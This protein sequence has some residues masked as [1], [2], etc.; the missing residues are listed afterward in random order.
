MQKKKN[1]NKF[2]RFLRV[3]VVTVKR[4]NRKR[5]KHWFKVN[6]KTH[7]F[8]LGL[9]F[10]VWIDAVVLRRIFAR[11]GIAKALKFHL[12][13]FLAWLGLVI[14]SNLLRDKQKVKWYLKKR[15]IFFMLI[16]LPPLGLILLWSGSQF[17]RITKIIFSIGFGAFFII[18]NLHYNKKYERLLAVPSFDRIVE[19]ITK[20]KKQIF[21]KTA[22]KGILDNLR[23][24]R[25]PKKTAAKLAVSEIA[26]RCSGSIVS[27][28][29][30]DKEGK[31]MGMGSGFIISEDGLIVTNFHV[32]ESAYQIEIKIGEKIFREAS[33]V[34]GISN[35]DIA[36]LK[37]DSK[38]LP[39]LP[40]GDSDSLVD[41][42]FVIVLGNPVGLER[43][44]SNGI[45]SA[46]RSKD[47]I[48]IIQ[49]TAPVSPGSSGG[50]VL[51]E[52]GE[53]VG[54]TTLASFFMAQNLNF[55]IPINYLDKILNEKYSA[56]E[57][58]ADVK[59]K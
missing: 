52:Y 53:V 31:E 17:K 33:L 46:I 2:K 23:L 5:V 50:P 36:L 58:R 15:F 57:K 19:M 42:Q 22:D 45:I 59:Q 38:G 41:G 30:K 35:M 44:V 24:T 6:L 13:I 26:A 32:M 10:F 37:I 16:I 8:I 4:I 25:I 3:I 40:I 54:I 39:A 9:V 49:M 43:S 34:K 47:D 18:A 51:N 11:E 12:Y 21:L 14:L 7:P 56:P 29:T 27:I 48:K 20:P 1:R 55:A 28:K